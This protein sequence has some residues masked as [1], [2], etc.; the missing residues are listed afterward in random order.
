MKRTRLNALLA[1]AALLLALAG[2]GGG[3][4]APSPTPAPTPSPTAGGAAPAALALPY[5]GES[6]HPVLST[7]KTDLALSGLLWEGLF[8]LTP[9]FDPQPLLC[10]SYAASEDGLT[11]TFTLRS[12]VTFSDG[13][14]LTA[15]DVAAS[16]QLARGPGSRFQ[17]RL[18]GITGVEAGEGAVTVTLSA[19]NGA[20]PALL[21]VPIFKDG[22][23][24]PLGTGPYILEGAGEDLR[25]TARQGWWQEKPLPI[26][27]ISLVPIREADDLLYAFSTGDVSLVSAD[28]TGTGALGFTGD[29]QV[30]DCPTTSMIYVG[31]NCASG[32]CAD[33]ALRRALDR[34]LDRNT[35]AVALYSRHAQAAELPVP[36]V[37]SLWDAARAEERSYSQQA[38]DELLAQAG[39]EKDADGRWARGRQALSLTMVASTSNTF[40]LSAAEY[41]A[42][43][44][45]KAG[46]EV[47]LRKLP[48]EEYLAAL[49]AG[50][51]DLYVGETM[52]SASFDLSPLLQSGGALNY[53]R[54]Q[55]ALVSP[56]LAAYQAASGEARTAAAG[57]LWDALAQEVPFSTLCFKNWSVLTHW[58]RVSGLS[59]THHDPFYG[60]ENWTITQ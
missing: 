18:A 42:S 4:G 34:G 25:L 52:L 39:Y 28:L 19:P 54:Y 10:Q 60:L 43:E 50:D 15:A 37:S 7:D 22:G 5:T 23:G 32:P 21:D 55:S 3:E 33:A 6:L 24:V 46:V 57:A 51:F 2:C 48:W 1:A 26:A 40:R 49:T 53:G 20:L 27:S 14:P 38:M 11:W 9:S 41:L 59:P 12:G 58:G 44:L 13:S 30:V 47:E 17:Q 56:L 45:T 16:L 36:P 8:V 31:Y 35:V 29:N